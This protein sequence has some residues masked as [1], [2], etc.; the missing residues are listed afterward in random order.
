MLIPTFWAEGRVQRRT[1]NKEILTVRRYGWSNEN[2]QSAQIHAD[3][4]ALEAW[5]RIADGQPLAL[6][7]LKLAYGSE[8]LPI[9]EQVVSQEDNTVITRNSYGAL[10][11]NTPDV[12]I[13]D[14]DFDLLIP[15]D[16]KNLLALAGTF[17]MGAVLS[18]ALLSPWVGLGFLVLL[19]FT[20]A[21]ATAYRTAKV[22]RA[23]GIEKVARARVR[24]FSKERP[25]WHIRVYRTPKGLRAIVLHKSML[26][27]DPEVADF[28]DAVGSDPQ[29]VK[30]CAQQQCFRAR[31]SPKPW[32][33]G[34]NQRIRSWNGLPSVDAK[35]K[36]EREIWLRSYD[37][38]AEGYAACQLV[39]VL[40]PGDRLTAHTAK[41][42]AMHDT[43]ARV[44]ADFP[45]A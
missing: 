38:V 27:D 1:G 34:I 19:L 44:K 22:A 8:G 4:R 6:R 43:L 41:V 14:I 36:H 35:R 7:D 2:Q 16:K 32:R 28:F 31:V 45:L 9:R 30:M 15:I 17:L 25:D 3:G 33:I 5:T 12:A 13:A 11:L 39:E 10:C 20:P 21:L 42:L 26:P 24:A 37:R 18:T 23:G 29:Y 40:G